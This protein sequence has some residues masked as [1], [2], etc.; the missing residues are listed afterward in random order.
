[1]LLAGIFAEVKYEIMFSLLNV[2]FRA[3]SESGV[4]YFFHMNTIL[5]FKLDMSFQN[6]YYLYNFIILDLA[7][8]A[9]RNNKHALTDF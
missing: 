7:V 9:S 8:S 4:P 5:F 6:L 3:K 1:M 2:D